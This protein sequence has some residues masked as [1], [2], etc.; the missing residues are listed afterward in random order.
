MLTLNDARRIIAAAE[1]KASEIGQPMNMQ[2][3][4]RGQSDCS[5]ED[6]RSLAGQYR[7]FNQESL[8]LSGFRYCNEGFACAQP[9][10]RTVFRNPRLQ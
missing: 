4:I 6:G 1:T 10:W 7:H 2:L 9:V 8:Y 5:R 3:P